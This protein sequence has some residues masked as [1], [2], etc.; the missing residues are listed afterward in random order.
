[1]TAVLFSR[2]Q[3]ECTHLKSECRFALADFGST[4]PG[5]GSS[6]GRFGTACYRDPE[7]INK[8]HYSEKTD[9]WAF[10][11]VLLEVARTGRGYAFKYDEEALEYAKT[12]SR[13]LLPQLL[14]SEN[15]SLT[16]TQVEWFN[17]VVEQCLKPIPEKRYTSEDLYQMFTRWNLN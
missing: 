2:V 13:D 9:I 15:P 7:L 6:T 16:E 1:M 3:C 11:C 5:E 8:G 10:G 4:K 17:Q 12:Q 14:G